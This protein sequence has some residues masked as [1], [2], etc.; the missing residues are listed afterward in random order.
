MIIIEN[1]KMPKGCYEC[2]FCD[3][4]ECGIFCPLLSVEESDIEH[5]IYDKNDRHPS[6]P[7]KEVK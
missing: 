6:C 5:Y 3:F 1:M 2:C 7:L 4:S